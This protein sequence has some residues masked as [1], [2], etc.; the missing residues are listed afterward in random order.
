MSKPNPAFLDLQTRQTCRNLV[1]TATQRFDQGEGGAATLHMLLNSFRLHANEVG[2]S[3]ALADLDAI[4][5]A[6]LKDVA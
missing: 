6:P 2:L 4:V 5:A 1:V 3:K